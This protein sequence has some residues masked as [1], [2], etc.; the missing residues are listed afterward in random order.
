MAR[1]VTPLPAPAGGAGPGAR[2]S[3]EHLHGLLS[4]Q[5]RRLVKLQPKV[6]ESRDTE[7]LH[8]MRVAMRRLRTCLIQFEPALVMPPQVSAGA[9]ARSGQRLGMA[10]DLDVLQERLETR[11]LA[12]LPT[13]EV[14]QLAPVIKRLRRQRHKAQKP[15]RRELTG[16]SYRP[17]GQALEGWLRDPRFTPLGE[18]PLVEWLVEWQWPWLGQLLLHP[19]WWVEEPAGGAAA[20]QLHDLRKGLKG[21]RYRLEN[22]QPLAGATAGHWLE[23]LKQ[24]QELLG[25][26]H[27]IAVL[28]QVI[29]SRLKG[30]LSRRL[31]RLHALLQQQQAASWASWRLLAER[32]LGFPQRR[33]LLQ[34]LLLD[35]DHLDL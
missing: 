8:Q 23:Q 22:L 11:L 12:H 6:L 26:L 2:S 24:A 5:A 19:A 9:L 29:E 28:R 25:D 15:L 18:R 21:A 10:R 13:E 17:M 27:D 31:P 33:Q 35:P 7:P 4:A 32:L 3:G 16:G 30:P 20:K 34:G 14:H 1:P